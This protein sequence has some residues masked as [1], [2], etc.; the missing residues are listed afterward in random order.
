MKKYI[1]AL[2]I[3]FLLTAC[4]DGN[5]DSTTPIQGQEA[6]QKEDFIRSFA[7]VWTTGNETVTIDYSDNQILILVGNEQTGFSLGDTDIANETLNIIGLSGSITTLKKMW[8][9]DKTTYKLSATYPD[10]KSQT[11]GFV[12]KI[13]TDDKNRIA[14]IV[15]LQ[16]Q[17]DKQKVDADVLEQERTDATAAKELAITQK[18]YVLVKSENKAA[19]DE[20]N[21]LW[22]SFTKDVKDALL[23]EQ[24][25]WVAK[26]KKECGEPNGTKESPAPEPLN[27]DGYNSAIESFECDTQKTEARIKEL[28]LKPEE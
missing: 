7:A 10:G 17:K 27:V 15:V 12:R 8:N 16:A 22:K 14:S 13:T 2:F 26:K 28:N 5:K 25:V 3:G 1:T 19:R 21:A 6:S 11:L 18:Q 24:K 20:L 9:A 4:S 23:E